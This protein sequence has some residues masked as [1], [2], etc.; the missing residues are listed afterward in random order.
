MKSLLLCVAFF[1][2]QMNTLQQRHVVHLQTA[3]QVIAGE[4]GGDLLELSN[5]PAVIDLPTVP[6]KLDSQRSPWS[7]DVKNLGP[8][9]V[10]VVGKNQFSV[11]INV[12]RTVRIY[13]DGT[14]YSLKPVGA[15]V[16]PAE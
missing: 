16:S 15:G 7:I 1:A 14:A 9:R 10:T 6:P 4:F 3:G 2:G 8:G 13:S 5:A 11:R 12:G